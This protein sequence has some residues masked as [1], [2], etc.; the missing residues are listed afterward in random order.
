MAP[1]ELLA[2]GHDALAAGPLE[3]RA[4]R[5][6]GGPGRRREPGGLLR[7]GR[8]PVVV[9][10]EPAPA[11][12]SAP[13]PTPLFR[14][15][16][17]TPGAVECAV[18][19]AITYKANFANFAAANGWV[20]RA[21][22][23]LE[24][25]RAS[26]PCTLG[27]GWPGP[28]GWTTSTPPRS[29]PSGRWR[30][31]ATLEDVDL[32]LVALAQLGLIGVGKGDT[33]AGL[34]ADRRGDGG[35]AGRGARRASTRS[36][37]PRATCSTPA[38]WPATSSGPSSGAGS[39]TTSSRPTAARSSTPSA[40]CST[41]ACWWPRAVG[42][43]PSR[44]W[45]PACG[46]PRA[47]ARRSTTGRSPGWPILRVRQG[48]LEEAERLLDAA[49]RAR[50][51]R[52]RGHAVGG[53]AAAG[54][55]RPGRGRRVLEERAHRLAGHRSQL[56]TALDHLVDAY[57]AAGDLAAAGA[58]ADRL[59]AGG[60]PSAARPALGRRRPA[61]RPRRPGER[62]PGHGP[63][64]QRRGRR[65]RSRLR[66]PRGPGTTCRSRRPGPGSSWAGPWRRR[67]P[68]AAVDQARL[69]LTSFEELGATLEA[70]RTA[71]FLRAMGVTART[72]AKGV[73]DADAP[74]AGGAAP[75]S[76]TVCRTPR[77]R[78]ACT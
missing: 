53:G 59:A 61:E 60:R 73:G 28:T 48:R 31:P 34:R 3:R 68:D 8:G 49:G 77:S 36:C 26:A 42:P 22:R 27:R 18:W 71:A 37:T 6:R 45:T 16:G 30:W 33:A 56:A 4:G 47:P 1:E 44:S 57:L 11:S 2:A 51:G 55:R 25:A 64:R 70:D 76:A 78:C 10:R 19:L 58:T 52:R 12:R 29:S 69:A 14:R 74:G 32:E 54:P 43:T 13:V 63:G 38:S 21:E 67:R 65:R 72:G 17:D 24:A 35:G 62:P 9:G 20:G 50:R 66:W 40:A 39:P 15:D 7:P 5:L 41:A 75:S 23:L 46:S